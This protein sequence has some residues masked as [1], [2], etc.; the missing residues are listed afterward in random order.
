[1]VS[2][3]N[4]FFIW[5]EYLIPFGSS[6]S[7]SV[8]FLVKPMELVK[9]YKKY[10]KKAHSVLYLKGYWF[11]WFKKLIINIDLGGLQIDQDHYPVQESH[12][13]NSNIYHFSYFL[14]HLYIFK[15]QNVTFS[16]SWKSSLSFMFKMVLIVLYLSSYD[17]YENQ[18][19]ANCICEDIFC[20]VGL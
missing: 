9:R 20:P 3:H 14:I 10:M 6:P 4:L 15:S 18:R 11:V 19:F 13:Y 8:I 12:L 1:M 16:I 17:L 7:F 2:V 5:E